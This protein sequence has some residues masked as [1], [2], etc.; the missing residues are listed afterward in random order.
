MIKSLKGTEDVLPPE[1]ELWYYLENIARGIFIKYGYKEIRTPTLEPTP[2]FVRGVGKDTDIVQKQMYTFLDQGGRNIC[3]RPEETASVVRAYIQHYLYKTQEFIKLFYFGSM[4]RSER[5]QAG[6]LRQFTHIG[7]EII[8]SY[9][10]YADC[11]IIILLDDLLRVM[12]VKG[13]KFKINSLG[14]Q[15]DKEKF[16][17]QL[18]D[19]LKHQINRF[20]QDCQKRYNINILR[21]L[22]C[23]NEVCR[24]LLRS[25]K[26]NNDYLCTE[27]SKHFKNVL[28]VIKKEGINYESNPFL[29]RGL[30][31][32]TKT[33]FEVISSGLGAQDAIAAG[34][35]YDNLISELGGPKT[36]ACGF[37]LGFERTLS[38]IN[39]DGLNYTPSIPTLFIVAM[40]EN[41]YRTAFDL[42][43][44]LRKKGISCDMDYANRSLKAQM[45][46]ADKINSKFVAI[47]GEDELKNKEVS[48][49]DMKTGEQKKVKF[50]Q[51][52][53]LLLP[54]RNLKLKAYSL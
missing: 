45:R 40:N 35:R 28:D 44:N 32:Y 20:C 29:V 13:Y 12:S 41:A 34:G 6:R 52:A 26:V 33:V 39:Q 36:G 1:S 50:G 27:C 43:H 2:L 25:L 14:C 7:V 37:A 48:L 21:I 19:E 17:K 24:R 53:N 5:P 31:Y 22:D 15:K 49:K 38:V 54:T 51:L 16:K 46:Y 8:G 23:K 47:I 30:D 9:S 18:K 3:L 10:H 11:E 42:Q 4:Y